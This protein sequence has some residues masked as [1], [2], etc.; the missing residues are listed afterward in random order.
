M[1]L[2]KENWILSGLHQ[3]HEIKFEA[4]GVSKNLGESRKLFV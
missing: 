1:E 4:A 2:R 3:V